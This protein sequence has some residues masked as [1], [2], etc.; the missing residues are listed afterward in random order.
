[1][2]AR[3]YQQTCPVARALDAVGER[4][5]LLIVRELLLG[6]ARYG[7]LLEALPSMGTKV[8]AERLKELVARDLVSSTAEGYR[9]TE[10]GAELGPVISALAAWGRP[11]LAQHEPGDVT[12]PSTVALMF[13]ARLAE[14][15]F[16]EGTCL[17]LRIDDRSF[18]ASRTRGEFRVVRGQS[19]VGTSR[20]A[21]SVEAAMG[22][23]EGQTTIRAAVAEGTLKLE[24]LS[25]RRV[26]ELF[27]F[28]LG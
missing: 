18:V 2:T 1:M 6:P 7:Q 12:P 22:L 25:V 14:A 20:V 16:E 28:E 5:A 15:P 3:R 24:Q 23:L 17:E 9:L 21:V 27:R 13:W 8:L 19:E 26:R 11:L 4:W 10:R